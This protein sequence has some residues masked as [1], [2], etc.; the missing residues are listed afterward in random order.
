M[1]SSRILKL[2][3]GASELFLA[4]PILGGAIVIG[5]GY[6]VLTVM[7]IFHIITLV[8]SN[9]NREPIYGS[10]LGIVTSVLAWIPILGWALHLIAGILLLIS[11]AQSGRGFTPPGQFH[12]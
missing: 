2:V 5:S 10:V 12:P 9:K 1:T 6:G 3:T 11:A 7:F 4:I 8:L